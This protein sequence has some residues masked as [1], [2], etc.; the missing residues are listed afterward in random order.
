MKGKQIS[1]TR[2][3]EWHKTYHVHNLGVDL[4]RDNA[5]LRRNVFEHFVQRL[6][7]D[8]FS[9]HITAGV[10]EIEHD[11]TLVKLLYKQVVAFLRRY[12]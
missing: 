10:I 8:L 6:R 5:A 11:R 4:F 9:L 2:C 12:L 3:N 1:T 7:F